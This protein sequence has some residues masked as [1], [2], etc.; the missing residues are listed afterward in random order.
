MD[1]SRVL[2]QLESIFAA[3]RARWALVGGFALQAYGVSRA[4]FDIDVASE[5]R[6]QG[7]I[8]TA[9]ERLGYQ[10]LHFSAGFTNH[11][12]DDGA[13]G[14]VDI[15]YVDAATAD[16]L[17]GAARPHEIFPGIEVPVPSVEH[18]IAMK[19]HAMKND[20]DR[21]LQDCADIRALLRSTGT[22]PIAV[23][24]WFERAHLLDRFDDITRGL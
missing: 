14:R 22:D 12:H 3:A 9:L 19:V 8:V 7:V 20:P 11:L 6:M 4:T 16:G 10:T 17:F 18:L 2:R 23:R 1:H 21:V 13:Q 24:P 5:A 15:V